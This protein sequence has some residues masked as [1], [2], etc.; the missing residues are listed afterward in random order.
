MVRRRPDESD[1][2]IRPAK[3]TRRRSKDRPSHSD[4][5]AAQVITVDRGRTLC[6]I[7][8][9]QLV[10]AMKARELGKNAVVTKRKPDRGNE[11]IK[12]ECQK[13]QYPRGNKSH[14]L[15]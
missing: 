13:T 9:G 14:P 8:S 1:I 4:S 2:R 15:D 10:S 7:A 3:S 12:I 11:G 6:R 5:I